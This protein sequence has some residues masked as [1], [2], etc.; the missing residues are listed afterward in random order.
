MNTQLVQWLSKRYED[1]YLIKRT[2]QTSV[3]VHVSYPSIHTKKRRKE[4]LEVQDNPYDRE[5]QY[6]LPISETLPKNNKR[7]PS[8]PVF[9]Q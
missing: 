8:G 3:V 2:T 5:V 6:K 7:F 1:L 4:D 9:P